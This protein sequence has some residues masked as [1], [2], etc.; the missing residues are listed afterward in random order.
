V[1]LD[2]QQWL[3][4]LGVTFVAAIVQG[5]VGFGYAVLA[6]PILSLVD[7]RLAPVP[8]I[9]TAFPLTT[10]AALRERST[11]DWRGV[12]WVLLGRI[13]GT[14]L[15]MGLLAVST[16]RTLDLLIGTFVLLSV[17]V[18]STKF[19]LRRSRRVDF[20]AGMLG[21]A[22][23]YVSGIGG[24]P[25]ALLFRN[26]SG[27]TIRASLGVVFAFGIALTVAG[28]ASTGH[29]S[30]L[31]VFLGSVLLA[32]MLAGMA[33]SRRLHARLHDDRVKLVVL[34]ISSLAAVGL[35]GRALLG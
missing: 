11:V 27:P 30:S 1:I 5:T 21:T 25:I 16:Q 22:T 6:V 8:Q 17:I 9:L 12:F 28:R 31:D 10:W 2:A 34:S 35:L 29:I 19:E 32:P 14:L 33:L 13:P 24:P 4:V 23:G 3:L 18:L 15:G 20:A 7:A 26:A